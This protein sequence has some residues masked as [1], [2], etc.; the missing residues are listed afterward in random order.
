MFLNLAKMYID[1][2]NND[3]LPD[4][5]TSWKIVVDSQFQGIYDRSV[6][7]YVDSMINLDFKAIYKVEDIIM[8]HNNFK[9]KSFDFLKDISNINIPNSFFI[10]FY[11]N[12]DKK[13]NEQ[14]HEF[15]S[16]WNELSAKNCQVK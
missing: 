11:K 3:S 13:L 4:V 8:H 2:I 14:L 12:L 15:I 10:D 6:K 7:Y 5:K 16:K 9:E 1:S